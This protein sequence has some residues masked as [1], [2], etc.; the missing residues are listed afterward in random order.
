MIEA[1][2]ILL[3]ESGVGKSS[4]AHRFCDDKFNEAHDVTI[5]AAYM[6]TIVALPTGQKVKLHIWDTGG[7][8]RF[9]TMVSLYYRDAQAALICYD[10]TNQDSMDSVRYWIDQMERNTNQEE[11]VIALVGNK[12]DAL[13]TEKRM[14]DPESILQ[15][16]EQYSTVVAET[17][18]RTGQGINELFMEVAQKIAE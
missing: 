12:V 16:A 7:S 14:V 17:S 4:I 2:I 6:Q 10:L 5:G 11:F 15:L 8:E 1:K 18:A 9:R 13:A 3:G